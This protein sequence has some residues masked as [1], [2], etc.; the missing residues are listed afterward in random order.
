MTIPKIGRKD[1]TLKAFP[2]KEK[3]EARNFSHFEIFFKII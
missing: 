3:E 2:G 1:K